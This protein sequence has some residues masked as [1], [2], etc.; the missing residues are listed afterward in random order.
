MDGEGDLGGWADESSSPSLPD[1]PS[2]QPAARGANSG[3]DGARPAEVICSVP[4][5]APEATG[6]AAVPDMH[7]KSTHRA[8]E[9]VSAMSQREGEAGV[10]PPGKEGQC[11]ALDNAQA[12]AEAP[13][14]NA[15]SYE[16][17]A[18]HG[19]PDGTQP[20]ESAAV[21]QEGAAVPAAEAAGAPAPEG[22]SSQPT[23]QISSTE[24][25]GG[26]AEEAEQQQQQQQ[27]QH[28]TSRRG[29]PSIDNRGQVLEGHAERSGPDPL[30]RAA[31]EG[32]L[33]GQTEGSGQEPDGNIEEGRH[34]PGGHTDRSGPDPLEHAERS[35]ARGHMEGKGQE[36]DGNLEVDEQEP[37][38]HAEGAGQHH[39]GSAAQAD[40]EVQSKDLNGQQQQQ[41]REG[42]AEARS[43]TKEEAEKGRSS[44]D[45]NEP[46]ERPKISF[47]KG[48]TGAASSKSSSSRPSPVQSFKA[49]AAQDVSNQE[50]PL[51]RS[52]S[53]IS[54]RESKED[55]LGRRL[56]NEAPAAGEE[57]DISEEA[58]RLVPF[59]L[60]DNT[61]YRYRPPSGRKMSPLASMKKTSYSGNKPM[62]PE[63]PRS[64]SSAS[65]GSPWMSPRRQTSPSSARP[66]SGGSNLMPFQPVKPPRPSPR[67]SPNRPGPFGI[68][69]F[70][71]QQSRMPSH[72]G[73]GSEGAQSNSVPLSGMV[74][75]QGQATR[76]ETPADYIVHPEKEASHRWSHIDSARSRFSGRWDDESHFGGV[77]A[78]SATQPDKP[79]KV[80]R[81]AKL[82]GHT[83]G[84]GGHS[85]KLME[86]GIEQQD[87]AHQD[88]LQQ[89]LGLEE[90]FKVK[91]VSHGDRAIPVDQHKRRKPGQ[92]ISALH[93]DRLPLGTFIKDKEGQ[94][95]RIM[96]A[97]QNMYGPQPLKRKYI[98]RPPTP[99][100][101]TLD[102]F[103]LLEAGNDELPE[104]V[105]VARLP[106]RNIQNVEVADMTY[107]TALKVL[108][109][110]D[111]RVLD[112]TLLAP[113]LG[114]RALSL[115]MNRLGPVPMGSMLGEPGANAF[116]MLS[117]LDLSY[118]SLDANATLSPSSP[119]SHLPA[120][121][122]RSLQ[123][124]DLTRN[125]VKSEDAIKPLQLLPCL[126]SVILAGNPLAVKH[127]QATKR[128]G[129]R[130]ENA[131]AKANSGAIPAPE[132][133]EQQQASSSLWVYEPVGQLGPKPSVARV[134]AGSGGHFVAVQE[135]LGRQDATKAA[136]LAAVTAAAVA[137]VFDR[138]D[139]AMEVWQLNTVPEEEEGED[140]SEDNE[141]DGTF[142][143]GVMCKILLPELQ[144]L[145]EAE[146]WHILD[147]ASLVPPLSLPLAAPKQRIP[148]ER[149]QELC[150]RGPRKLD[151]RP[152]NKR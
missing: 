115:A 117:T 136:T 32:G 37:D 10:Q 55:E 40:G 72:E 75:V 84:V 97:A 16:G 29:G 122:F 18:S 105:V 108:D 130:R 103:L 106:S 107:F 86:L 144:N 138:A 59:H 22:S 119:L 48:K 109:L 42:D 12:P 104:G 19:A 3:N 128:A 6:S 139:A 147:R 133:L 85:A 83:A 131:K 148:S 34:G 151:L 70:N 95:R 8:M 27:Q 143:T 127:A 124:L 23:E 137:E 89:Q 77:D 61:S 30:G 21:S 35:G 141:P 118:N 76:G 57:D 92:L 87:G 14:E 113:L 126:K 146:R 5:H 112:M 41:H 25:P 65:R 4:D 26:V 150:R 120:T 15:H 44:Q 134:L 28:R 101:I 24:R 13:P 98:P 67:P 39:E 46:K 96:A 68:R 73:Q 45:V 58:R 20:Q 36:P 52:A 100:G 88:A 78:R 129:E 132:L 7:A 69:G 9:G 145:P 152:A 99:E 63:H 17:K 116:Q 81:N 62:S 79:T 102:G 11:S 50:G 33:E 38:R 91:T 74:S 123:T 80:F 54:R 110:A 114:I 66:T 90:L 2:V 135:P 31:E 94:A 125:Q 71:Q 64:A 140:E 56:S 53:K 51:K 142:L 60:V 121:A 93:R 1:S 47:F 82:G 111:N 149:A 49:R 43:S